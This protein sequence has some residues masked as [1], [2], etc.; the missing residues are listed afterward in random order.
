MTDAPHDL[1]RKAGESDEEYNA[2]IDQEA[3]DAGM[4]RGEYV[5]AAN[6]RAGRPAHTSPVRDD[7]Q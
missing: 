7:Q 3:Q 1:D 2:R 4:D 5:K 6:L